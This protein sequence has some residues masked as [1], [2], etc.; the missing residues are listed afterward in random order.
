MLGL[1]LSVLA[2]FLGW[3]M[4]LVIFISL[5]MTMAVAAETSP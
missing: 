1:A 5:K 3:W 2:P 4:A